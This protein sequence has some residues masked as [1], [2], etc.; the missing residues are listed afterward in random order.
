MLQAKA[1]IL[2]LSFGA[3]GAVYAATRNLY[4]ADRA[5]LVTGII[6][7]EP[8]LVWVTGIGL[9]ENFTLL[10]STLTLWA[11]LRSLEDTR[12]ILLAGI[13]WTVVYLA[14]S[15]AGAFGVVPAV[16]GAWWWWKFRGW[17]ACRA[18]GA[19]APA[20]CSWRRR[21]SGMA[22]LQSLRRL[23]NLGL[24]QPGVRLWLCPPCAHGQGPGRKGA[25]FLLFLVAYT[26]PF[27][28]R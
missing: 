8:S 6:A 4:G 16:A 7:L 13:F 20:S 22:Q 21:C 18:P 26:V 14:R 10:F 5:V 3:L 2:A 12:Y 23:G 17:R 25:F 15:S 19:S 11:F 1:A 9:S 27:C 24:R 28:P